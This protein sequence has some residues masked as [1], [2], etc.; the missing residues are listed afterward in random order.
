MQKGVTSIGFSTFISV[1]NPECRA[2]S[3]K[4][5]HA[6]ERQ[7]NPNARE[8]TNSNSQITNIVYTCIYMFWDDS[9]IL[10]ISY[11]H[12]RIIIHHYTDMFLVKCGKYPNHSRLNP[13]HIPIHSNVGGV[14]SRKRPTT[15]QFAIMLY[16][17]WLKSLF[18]WIC[19]RTPLKNTYNPH[20]FTK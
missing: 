17:L 20:R 3:N 12:Q 2:Q 7:I 14:K 8:Q 9:P 13:Y 10:A 15:D 5:F 16:V 1:Y 11:N 4:D 18:T 19:L 6:L